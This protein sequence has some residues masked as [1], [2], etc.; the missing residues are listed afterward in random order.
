MNGKRNAIIEYALRF[1][2]D[3][4]HPLYVAY[5]SEKLYTLIK[6]FIPFQH[7]NSDILVYSAILH[8]IGWYGGQAKH[9][10][11]SYEMIINDPPKNLTHDDIALIANIT[12]YHRKA[13]PKLQ[14]YGYSQLK[15]ADRKTVNY[16]ASILRIADGLDALHRSI[17]E[18]KGCYITSHSVEIQIISESEC[19]CEIDSAIGKADLFNDVFNRKLII[20]KI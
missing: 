12:R 8:D 18:V 2:A 20:K 7:Q 13:L 14:H 10:K 5:L 17:V 3:I 6:P 19:S 16:L 11:L 9:H 15:Q 1:D 4:S